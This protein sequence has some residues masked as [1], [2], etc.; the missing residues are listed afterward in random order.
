LFVL[1]DFLIATASVVHAV[2]QLAWFVLLARIV[3]SWVQPNPPPG[4][5][6]SIVSAIYT[7]TD[8]VLD[9]ARRLLPFLVVQG[10]DLSPIAVFLALGFLDRFLTSTL[11][12]LGASLV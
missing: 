8:P 5:V 4:V 2:L 1:G 9:R 10:V 12:H 7:L 3:L 11:L 6:R